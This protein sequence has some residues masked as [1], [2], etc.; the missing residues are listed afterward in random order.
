M[1]SSS[2]AATQRN[3]ILLAIAEAREAFKNTAKR[4]RR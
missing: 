1:K 3:M 4:A 2:E